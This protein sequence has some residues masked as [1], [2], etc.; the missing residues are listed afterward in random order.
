MKTAL[1]FLP[2]I[3]GDKCRIIFHRVES[4]KRKSILE[5]IL[6]DVSNKSGISEETLKS[7]TRIREVAEARQ[8]YFKRA[9][10]ITKLSLAAIGKFVNRD[11]A[12]VIHGIKAV[13][14]IREL[15]QKY[16][17]YF[18]EQEVKRN[19]SEI[20]LKCSDPIKYVKPYQFLEAESIQPFSG[21]REH[22]R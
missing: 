7:K 10:Q 13:N 1:L 14:N 5:R 17:E 2:K 21:Y 6:S 4:S 3:N 22:S 15:R 11:H 19:G 8:I 9:S 16:S 18:P 12:T 20:E